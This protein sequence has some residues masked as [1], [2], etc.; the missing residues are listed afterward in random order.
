VFIDPI[1]VD[2]SKQRIDA[3]VYSTETGEPVAG[4]EF[5]RTGYADIVHG[6]YRIE[7]RMPAT[8]V[9][10]AEDVKV[11]AGKSVRITP[12]LGRIAV[13][14][15]AGNANG[16]AEIRSMD[17]NRVGFIAFDGTLYLDVPAGEYEFIVGQK[18]ELVTVKA[19]QTQFVDR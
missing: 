12:N 4:S 8:S 18:K 19:R 7:V 6:T 5:S 2:G 13:R 15:G 10:W 16:S 11:E 14:P 17:G 1:A 9:V 3:T